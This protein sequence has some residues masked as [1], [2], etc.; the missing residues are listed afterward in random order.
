MYNNCFAVGDPLRR[1]H[2]FYHT[3]VNNAYKLHL[4]CYENEILTAH[5][6]DVENPSIAAGSAL[7]VAGVPRLGLRVLL[8]EGSGEA[9]AAAL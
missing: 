7:R 8:R 2:D 4:S 5:L 3:Y 1:T 6:G 9:A